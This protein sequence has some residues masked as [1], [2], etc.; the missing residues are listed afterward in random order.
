MQA[1]EIDA[2][3]VS[4]SGMH[5]PVMVYL[6]GGGHFTGDYIKKRGEPA[7]LFVGL[8]ERDEAARTGLK[9]G[10]YSDFPYSG[11]LAEAQGNHIKANAM[12]YSQ[13]LASVGITSGRLALYGVGELSHGFAVFSTLQE[14]LPKIQFAPYQEEDL[15]L[16]A[17]LTKDAAEVERI[18]R[19][20]KITTRVVAN[21]ADFLRGHAVKDEALV[22]ADGSP[23]TAGDVKARID[24]WLAEAGAESPEGVI[25]STG[26]DAGVPH[27]SGTPDAAMRL[28]QTIVFDI[29]PCEQGGGYF[30]DFTR[31]WCLGYA[32][33]E[34]EEAYTQVLQV[35]RTILSELEVDRDF[36]VYQER[37]CSLFAA[38]GHPTPMSHPGTQEGY[39]HGLGHGI[40]LDVHE[41]PYNG[42]KALKEEKLSRGAVITIEPG[43]YYPEKGFGVRLEDSVWVR[44]DGK[45]EILAEYPLDLVLQ[46]KAS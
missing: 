8:M 11:L 20:G 7:V 46:M 2:L 25:F 27:S 18:R 45:F 15:I 31:T 24:L 41:R 28:G 39:V 10:S 30:Y 32:P 36:T 14:M 29:Y 44:P 40:G 3:L 9:V 21:T 5:N 42:S 23:L 13:M 19:M 17:R 1:N 37:A 22:K 43:L 33:P 35:Y 16:K 4:G 34:V 12:R 38:M 6:T 26:R